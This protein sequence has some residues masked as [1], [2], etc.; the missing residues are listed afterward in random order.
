MTDKPTWYK[1]SYERRYGHELLTKEPTISA[2]PLTWEEYIE[3]KKLI[4]KDFGGWI[5]ELNEYREMKNDGR[6]VQLPCKVGDTVYIVGNTSACDYTV[7]EFVVIEEGVS[8]IK[9][10]YKS[11]CGGIHFYNP[12]SPDA[13]GRYVFFNKEAAENRLSKL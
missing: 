10:E 3:M 4:L 9:V 5:Q 1:K 7:K 11:G 2:E 6:L 13:I 8:T 12:F